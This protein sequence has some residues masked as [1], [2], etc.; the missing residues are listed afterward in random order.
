M[1]LL[2]TVEIPEY[3]RAIKLSE[4]RRTAYYER[5]KKKLPAKL[6][7]QIGVNM[8]WTFINGKEYLTDAY[9]TRIIANPT[10]AGTPKVEVIKGNALHSLRML[11]STRSKI[12]KA[13]K[14][15]MTRHIEKLEP[16]T[17]F[18]IRIICEIHDTVIDWMYIDN[19]SGLPKDTNW[20]I[21]NRFLFYGKAFPDI[22]S[23]SPMIEEVITADR[24]S[25]GKR[26]KIKQRVFT[27]KRIIPDD[28]RKFITQPPVPLFC[29]IE[30][31]T[32]RKLVFKIYH[33]DREI[34]KNNPHYGSESYKA[35]NKVL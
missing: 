21:D 23:G 20:D 1:E 25:S 33:D 28:G 9:G 17:K 13:I 34:I 8:K 31:T 30:D 27:S 24:D 15:D 6:E 19:K 16:I 35:W 11:D 5:G 12:L 29:P 22:L 3:V 4:S 10:S 7:K 14:E 2:A 26:I 18:P 32:K